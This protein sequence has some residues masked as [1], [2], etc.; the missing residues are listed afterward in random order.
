[1]RHDSTDELLLS[2]ADTIVVTQ[3]TAAH[4]TF[5]APYGADDT[6]LAGE[7]VMSAKTMRAMG[8]KVEAR[9]TNKQSPLPM[10]RISVRRNAGFL[11]GLGNQD[12]QVDGLSGNDIKS[13]QPL[14]DPRLKVLSR[15]LNKQKAL[16][17]PRTSIRRNAG[18][19]PG[20]GNTDD[21][22]DGDIC[23]LGAAPARLKPKVAVH[24]GPATKPTTVRARTP[25]AYPVRGFLPGMGDLNL[26]VSPVTLALVAVGAYLLFR[27]R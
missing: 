19:L 9:G 17:F 13:A 26:G 22:D 15:G 27:K 21:A 8:V 7:G 6:A 18:F 25:G 24:R 1:M 4:D 10:P 5:P 2:P 16:P 14:A 23:G 20:L 11:P 12:F 3:A